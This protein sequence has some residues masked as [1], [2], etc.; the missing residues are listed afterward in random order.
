MDGYG[1]LQTCD[2]V[3]ELMFIT[4]AI[5]F[6]FAWSLMNLGGGFMDSNILQAQNWIISL[7]GIGRQVLS[8]IITSK[9]SRIWHTY[10]AKALSHLPS[11]AP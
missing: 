6:A 1:D 7:Y 8:A 5:L 9:P 11:G 4:C 10:Y 2:D 3:S